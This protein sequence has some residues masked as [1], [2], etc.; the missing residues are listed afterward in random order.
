MAT[1]ASSAED[2]LWQAIFSVSARGL[3][4]GVG[5]EILHTKE[6]SVTLTATS[7][8]SLQ[9]RCLCPL[10]IGLCSGSLGKCAQPLQVSEPCLPLWELHVQRALSQAL[11]QRFLQT[12]CKVRGEGALT[13]PRSN[14]TSGHVVFDALR[15][16]LK[17]SRCPQLLIFFQ[18]AGSAS[19]EMY[20]PRPT[21]L[22]CIIAG[23]ES[24]GLQDRP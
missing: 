14:S 22:A 11:L 19:V 1:L 24:I 18:S 9:A 13:Y 6:A 7:A 16:P 23:V 10:S 15:L 12:L 20:V 2:K 3:G 17:D 21:A 4:V 8:A 5:I